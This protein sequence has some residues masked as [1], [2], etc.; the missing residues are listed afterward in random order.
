MTKF[1]KTLSRR[2]KICSFIL[3]LYLLTA[4]FAPVL[5]PYEVT[6]FSHSSLEPPSLAHLLGTDE[7]GHD[8]F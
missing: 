5:M 7:M 1:L 6:D 3:A 4:L 2:Q 8:I